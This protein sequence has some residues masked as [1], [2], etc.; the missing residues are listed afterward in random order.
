MDVTKTPYAGF[1]E[2][3][4]KSVMELKPEKIAVT[5]MM[6]DGNVMTSAYGDVGPF[7]LMTMASMMQADAMMEIAKANAKDIIKAAEEDEDE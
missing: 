6:P 5:A 1:L 4:I 2:A 3:L 7:D